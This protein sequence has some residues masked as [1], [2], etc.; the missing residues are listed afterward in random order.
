MAQVAVIMTA[1]NCEDY[2][3]PAISSIVNQ[4]FKDFEFIIVDDGSTDRTKEFIAAFSDQRIKFYSLEHIGRARALNY[5]IS[6]T[7]CLYIAFMDADDI[8]VPERIQKQY[9]YLQQNPEIGLVSGWYAL[10]DSSGN[11]M[12]ILKK[13]PALHKE[14]EF[15]MTIQCSACFPASMIRLQL[16]SQ[17]FGFNEQLKSAI[18]YD[19]FLRILPIC[20]FSNLQELLLYHRI[21][22]SRITARYYSEQI[23]NTFR[24]ANSYLDHLLVQSTSQQKQ[25]NVFVRFGINEYYR[26]TMHAARHYFL[27]ALP[28]LWREWLVW[29]YLLP[30]FLGDTII[31]RYR[32]HSNR[33]YIKT[34]IH[35]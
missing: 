22:P 7:Q 12:S 3:G 23:A 9:R 31:S 8:S 11:E 14:I 35:E 6:K 33:K 25:Y 2:I 19:L 10:I 1:Y 32:K 34:T 28:E 15:E 24:L 27:S 30:T 29:R 5:A 4:S 17:V 13:L 16:L 26:G 18:D 20:R 21:H